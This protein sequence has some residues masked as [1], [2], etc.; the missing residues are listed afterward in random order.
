[1][2]AFRHIDQYR[3]FSSCACYKEG[4]PQSFL[5]KPYIPYHI[6]MLYYRQCHADDVYFLKAVLSEHRD[7]DV[8]GYEYD[9]DGVQICVCDSCYEIRRSGATCRDDCRCFTRD[10]CVGVRRV[11]GALFVG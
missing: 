4:L 6:T 10:S 9:R 3:T 11:R 7:R 5:E 2:D 8:A 1:L